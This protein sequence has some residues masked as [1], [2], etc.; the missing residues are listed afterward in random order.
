MRTDQPSRWIKLVVLAVAMAFAGWQLVAEVEGAYSIGQSAA[1]RPEIVGVGA[2][3]SE[4]LG[5]DDNPSLV[6]HLSG[7]IHGSLEPCG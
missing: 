6:V 7:D 4:R 1:D 2:T 3:M 5:D